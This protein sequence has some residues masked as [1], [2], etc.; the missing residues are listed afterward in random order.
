[1]PPI[2]K[3][4]QH[5]LLFWIVLA[6]MA[7]LCLRDRWNHSSRCENTKR[8]FWDDGRAARNEPQK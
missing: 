7:G 6:M 1:M 5:T 8:I 2:L 4:Y 3:R